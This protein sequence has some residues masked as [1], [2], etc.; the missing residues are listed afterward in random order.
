VGAGLSLPVIG[1]LLGHRSIQATARYAH[2]AQDPLKQATDVVG[3]LLADAPKVRRV[4]F[5][6]ASLRQLS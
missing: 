3:V 2:L 6:S 1:A 4:D 5:H